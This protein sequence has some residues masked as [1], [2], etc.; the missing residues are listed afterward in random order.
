LQCPHYANGNIREVE[1]EFVVGITW[2]IQVSDDDTAT[3]KF[4]GQKN[5]AGSHTIFVLVAVQ[6]CK[7]NAAKLG[8]KI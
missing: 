4:G 1:A 7:Y 2:E 5:R 3:R 8:K 6:R